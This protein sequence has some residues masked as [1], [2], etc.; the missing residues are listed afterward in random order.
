MRALAFLAT[1]WL[2]TT[3]AAAQRFDVQNFLPSPTHRSG[4]LGLLGGEV[5]PRD[6]FEAGI[7]FHY[8]DSQLVLLGDDGERIAEV[9]Q[10]QLTANVLGGF[11]LYGLGEVLLDVPLIMYQ[12]GDRLPDLPG[13]QVDGSSA[14]FGIGDI[15]VLGKFG[16]YDGNTN[17]SPGGLALA[18]ALQLQLPTGRTSDYQG[19]EFR[20]SPIVVMDAIGRRGH[21][22]TVNVGYT[23][24]PKTRALGDMDV[25]DTLDY[26]LALKLVLTDWMKT[27]V[28]VRGRISILADSLGPEEAPLEAMVGVRMNSPWASLQV[29]GGMGIIE[30]F[31]TPDWRI[32]LGARYLG[33]PERPRYDFDEDGIYDDVDQCPHEAE[34]RDGFED[35]DGCPEN[36]RIYPEAEP[37][38]EAEAE[39]EPEAEAEAEAEADAEGDADV[40]AGTEAAPRVRRRVRYLLLY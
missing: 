34:D 21:A 16:L 32:M 23:L 15:R 17:A 18:A 37:E 40:D 36:E 12:D 6:S 8:A 33:T 38:A 1:S 20:L 3:S 31:G 24:R 5:L 22:L 30:G 26:G 25:D 19:G 4:T 29:A 13:G 10:G 27:F 11:G 39:P 2:L 28:E 9:V 35:R 7:D 14:N